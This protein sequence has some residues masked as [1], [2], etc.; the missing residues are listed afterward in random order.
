MDHEPSTS[1]QVFDT[2][3]RYIEQHGY[4]PSIREIAQV[5]HLG[6]STVFYTLHKLEA[7]GW[8]SR[9]PTTARSLRVHRSRIKV[10]SEN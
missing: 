2:I 6:S 1:E 3:C 9:E 5:C 4:A 10:A 8:I 7:W